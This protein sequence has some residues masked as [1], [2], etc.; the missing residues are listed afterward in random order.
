[1]SISTTTKGCD[2]HRTRD[3]QL[4]SFL[5]VSCV[6]Y[7]SPSIRM[8]GLN[9]TQTKLDTASINIRVYPCVSLG[10]VQLGVVTLFF[11]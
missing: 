5:L 3:I 10:E 4:R 2:I 6:M 7:W 1:M 8:E 11:R 9:G